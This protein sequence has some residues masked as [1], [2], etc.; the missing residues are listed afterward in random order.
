MECTLRDAYEPGVTLVRAEFGAFHLVGPGPACEGEADLRRWT[1]RPEL[2]EVS[3]LV[4]LLLLP[5]PT[6]GCSRCRP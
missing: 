4:S 1:V 2:V 3:P 6:R 5:G